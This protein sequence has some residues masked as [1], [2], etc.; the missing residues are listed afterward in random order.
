MCI[1]LTST[2]RENSRDGEA[3]LLR[4]QGIPLRGYIVFGEYNRHR[5]R[6]EFSRFQVNESKWLGCNE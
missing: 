3:V 4:A 2:T 5:D 6:K 1:K